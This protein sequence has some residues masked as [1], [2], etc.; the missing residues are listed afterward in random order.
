MLRGGGNNSIED[1]IG[2]RIKI[3]G[4][5]GRGGNLTVI[6]KDSNPAGQPLMVSKVTTS[7]Q[8]RGKSV[9]IVERAFPMG[10]GSEKKE[11]EGSSACNTATA[12]MATAAA[13][14]A[15]ASSDIWVAFR[16]EGDK[17]CRYL[18][19]VLYGDEMRNR[20]AYELG[21]IKGLPQDVIP[22]VVE[23]AVGPATTKDNFE[24]SG[25]N[26][27]PMVVQEPPPPAAAIGVGNQRRRPP[28]KLQMFR[29]E[30]QQQRSR[31]QQTSTVVA[32]KSLFGSYWRHQWWENTISQKMGPC[33]AD[34]QF[35]FQIQE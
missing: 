7:Q 1:F 33:L 21:S 29:L 3:R 5:N 28:N 16:L 19:A 18:T 20:I 15:S 32:V 26:Y 12:V 22:Q 4:S 14:T 2:R 27:S 35:R 23:Y 10:V 11:E 8:S 17:H 13:P 24:G 34:E 25:F 31:Q 30:R 6:P 9:F